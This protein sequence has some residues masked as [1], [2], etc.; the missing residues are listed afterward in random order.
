[1]IGELQLRY[2]KIMGWVQEVRFWQTQPIGFR[3]GRTHIWQLRDG[4]GVAD[5]KDGRYV[6]HR[7]YPTLDSAIEKHSLMFYLKK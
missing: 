5:L 1:M 7:V 3:K 4:W 2:L 6:N